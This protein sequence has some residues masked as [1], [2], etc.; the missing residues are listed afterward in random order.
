[1]ATNHPYSFG[2][3]NDIS[4]TMETA[5]VMDNSIPSTKKYPDPDSLFSMDPYGHIRKP[6]CESPN[7]ESIMEAF[8]LES[9]NPLANSSEYLEEHNTSANNTEQTDSS[10]G[11]E[12]MAGIEYPDSDALNDLTGG[13]GNTDRHVKE[14]T[15]RF[16]P[17]RKGLYAWMDEGYVDFY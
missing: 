6:D 4:E 1:M 12:P 2:F 14:T 5:D 7:S 9:D 11:E 15:S 10:N 13:T 16:V 17:R 8:G 3:A